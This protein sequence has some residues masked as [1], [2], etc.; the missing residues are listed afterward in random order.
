MEFSDL[1][2]SAQDRIAAAEI[3]AESIFKRSKIPAKVARIRAK[4][5]LAKPESWRDGSIQE[6]KRFEQSLFDAAALDSLHQGR[7]QAARHIF[8]AVAEEYII[9]GNLDIK[10]FDAKLESIGA[11]V[12]KRFRV[13]RAWVDIVIQGWRAAR[14]KRPAAPEA[15]G[16]PRETI[17]GFGTPIDTA[18]NVADHDGAAS[19]QPVTVTGKNGKT[20]AP[21]F[22]HRASWLKDRLQ[23]RSWNKN[24]LSRHGGP[25]RKTVQKILNGQKIREEGHEKVATALS[26]APAS[27]K[28]P[29]VALLDIP[30]D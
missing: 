3:E 11:W 16:S 2:Q 28:L 17:G 23:E 29:Q 22:P 25:D 1:P 26:K 27:K 15:G 19:I 20:P 13:K 10:Q 18:P 24:D 6:Q 30:Q 21:Q 7:I 8:G 5:P 14:R 4:N 12:C 9:A